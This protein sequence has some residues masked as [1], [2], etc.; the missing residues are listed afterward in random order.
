[1]TGIDR[2]AA[3]QQALDGYPSGPDAPQVAL[4]NATA[5]LPEAQSVVLVEGISDQIALEVL[6][7]RQGIDLPSTG[8]VILP[9]GGARA[10]FTYLSMLGPQGRDLPLA[11]LC[12]ADA[13]ET[14]RR[15]LLRADMAAPA[16]TGLTGT[17]F[18]VCH[19]DLEDELIRA[20]GVDTMLAVI[21]AQ[22]ELGS[23]HTMQKQRQWRG[24]DTADQLH[25]FLRSRA[26]RGQRYAR[27]LIEAIEPGQ[28]PD[29]LLAVL[30]G[31]P[32]LR[33]AP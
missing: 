9:I 3:A 2:A 14:F 29:P 10:A 11:G 8:A 22:G 32:H 21:E 18:H 19:R 30:A 33:P 27:L 26:T 28:A 17:G 25:R 7:A 4:A 1:M 6:A 16:A 12:D 23:F 31:L 24:R 13:A 15:A 20:A 5:L